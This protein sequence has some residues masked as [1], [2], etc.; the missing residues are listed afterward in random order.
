MLEGRY[1]FLIMG[2]KVSLDDLDGLESFSIFPT[3]PSFPIG[4]NLAQGKKNFNIADTS[5]RV[6]SH[7]KG[8]LIWPD[9][10]FFSKDNLAIFPSS[11]THNKYT[12]LVLIS[13]PVPPRDLHEQLLPED[14]DVVGERESE[15]IALGPE[16]LGVDPG[17]LRVLLVDIDGASFDQGVL[18]ERPW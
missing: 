6:I 9:G 12:Y 8:S 14:V 3:S 15:V 17:G 5:F 4:P 16:A 13:K 11:N 7:T 1:D 18:G 2:E 10:V